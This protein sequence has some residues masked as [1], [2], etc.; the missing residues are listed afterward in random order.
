MKKIDE[1]DALA[2]ITKDRQR[3]N[4]L[5]KYEQPTLAFLVRYIPSWVSSDMLTAV[6]F[7]GSIM[8]LAGFSAA[9]HV[10]RGF[11][12][13]CILGFAINWFGDSL[14]GR[15]AYFRSKSRRWYGFALDVM[16]DWLTTIFIGLGYVV[17][18]GG[19]WELLGFCFVVLYGWAMMMAL[20]RY[21]ITGVHT[22]DSGLLGPTETRIIISAALFLEILFPDFIIYFGAGACLLLLAINMSDSLKLLKV[23]N[24]C[25]KEEL[26]SK[27]E[28]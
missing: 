24:R 11:L 6:G 4:I 1:T 15:L 22:I 9:T 23:A 26:R 21:K 18:V 10:H 3:T 7:G 12:L 8:V 17:Y 13:L 2:K 5:R 25:D 14:D 28:P 20:L 27:K 16:A 19:A